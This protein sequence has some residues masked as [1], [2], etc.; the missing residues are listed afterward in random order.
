MPDRS[1]SDPLV[2]RLEDL[3]R[4]AAADH[5]EAITRAGEVRSRL[6]DVIRDLLGM[7]AVVEEMKQRGL[8]DATAHTE[9]H[10]L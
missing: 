10:P 8:G 2:G 9:R 6:T 7:A 3:V 1:R 5:R 4:D